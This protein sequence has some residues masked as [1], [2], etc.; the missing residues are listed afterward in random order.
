MPPKACS[1][2]DGLL[3][4]PKTPARSQST[5]A[6]NRRPRAGPTSSS[7]APRCRHKRRQKA[8]AS[9]IRAH[10]R[11]S[12]ADTE[13]LRGVQLVALT[14]VSSEK[15]VHCGITAIE[16]L[17]IM[18]LRDCFFSPG[19]QGH[20]VSGNAAIAACSFALGFGGFSSSRGGAGHHQS[21]RRHGRRSSV[22]RIARPGLRGHPDVK[23]TV[24]SVSFI[25]DEV[26][27]ASPAYHW[28]LNHTMSVSDPLELFPTHT[29]II[30]NGQIEAAQ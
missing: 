14:C 22:P 19:W 21:R 9:R 4:F 27:P 26:I 13:C 18:R 5:P 16:S 23:G 20:I 8:Q 12:N 30:A 3:V 24:G 15:V 25:L 6:W 29:A 28:T 7:S 2:M 17:V 11:C 1:A 10:G